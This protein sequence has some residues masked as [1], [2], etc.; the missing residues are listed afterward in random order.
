M[1]VQSEITRIT[2]ARNTL[3]TKGVSLGIFLNTDDL[4]AIAQKFN[5]IVDRG[6]PGAQVKEGETYTI[7]P[8]Y[9]K[10]G[11]VQ[12]VAGG[13][14]YQLQA[15]STTPTKDS[16]QIAPDDGYYGLSSVSIAAIPDQYQDVSN[17]TATAADVL[18]G[19]V[20]V[21]DEGNEITGTMLN[22][23]AVTS[24]LDAGDS[25]TIPAGYHSGTGKVTANS[26]ASQTGVDE[27]KTAI[28]AATVLVGSQGWVNGAKVSGTMANNTSSTHTL[29]AGDSYTIP[30]GYHDGEGVVQTSSL[31]S[32]TGVETGKT[33]VAAAQM[34]IG[35]QGWV[36]GARVTGTMPNK[37][38]VTA[39]LTGLGSVTGDTVYAI[40]AGYHDGTGTVSVTSDIET[41][42]AAI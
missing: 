42:L 17:V 40:P 41:A 34:L 11:T 25:Y 27:G 3:R 2:S 37:G 20:F 28:V 14:N 31:S 15:K 35:Y 29:D 30:A 36:N 33:A 18:T 8:G 26:L 9:Y 6:S 21:D 22:R 1:S 19:K 16:Q 4:S 10:G 39:T 7:L 13:S 32:Q 38:K 23:G 12:G 24:S 5:A